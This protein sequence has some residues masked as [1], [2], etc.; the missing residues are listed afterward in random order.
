ML[1]AD[2]KSWPPGS[3]GV[4]VRGRGGPRSGVVGHPDGDPD[5]RGHRMAIRMAGSPAGGAG[6][7]GG[8]APPGALLLN[9]CERNPSLLKKRYLERPLWDAYVDVV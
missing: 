8:E 5:G 2:S 1:G 3:G 4:R 6:G 9:P 7:G